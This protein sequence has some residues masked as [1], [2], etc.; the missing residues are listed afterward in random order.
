MLTFA[1]L[2]ALR[3]KICAIGKSASA[4]AENSSNFAAG[5]TMSDPLSR[6]A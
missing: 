1:R 4:Y 2:F 3:W 5:E 6:V